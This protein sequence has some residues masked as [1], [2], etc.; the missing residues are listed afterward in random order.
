MAINDGTSMTRE[1]AI[2]IGASMG[3]LC[4]AAALAPHYQRVTVL[5]RDS[6]PAEPDHRRAVPQSRHAHGLQPGGLR[7]VEALLPGI[8]EE[9]VA[10]GARRGDQCADGVWVIGGIRFATAATGVLAVGVS[11]PFLEHRVR[12]RVA[13]LPNV[14][15]QD[16]VA[17]NSLI[18]DDPARVRGVVTEPAGGGA[19]ERVAAD[20]VVDATGKVSKLPAWLSELGYDVPDAER[21]TCRMAYLTRRWRL[22]SDVHHAPVVT[23]IAPGATPCFGVMIAQE[24]GTHIVTVGGLLDNAPDKTDASYQEHL[25]NLPDQSI[26]DALA[27]ATPVSEYQP[28]HF[29]ASVRRRFD[30]MRSFPAGLLAIGDAIAA[31]NPM[32]GQGMSVAAL[33]AVELRTML[34]QGPLDPRKFFAAA[35]RLEDVAWKIS[36]GGDLRYDEVE[37]KRTPDMKIM[38]RYLDRLGRAAQRDPVLTA[39]FLNVAGFIDRPESMFKPSIL[40]R[41]LRGGGRRQSHAPGPVPAPSPRSAET[42]ERA[43]EVV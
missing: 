12:N 18:A 33:E 11:R 36:T 16:G 10:D 30:R 25:R 20:L 9:L 21:V 41:V 1:H 17:V 26:T 28:S 29:P 5:D 14:T 2:V 27:G 40:I 34:A 4:A 42:V 23:V 31:F 32:Y 24:D 35:H 19:T 15:I 13:A 8:E 22:S 3:G 43:T 7:A 37:G 38:N 6:L 39:K